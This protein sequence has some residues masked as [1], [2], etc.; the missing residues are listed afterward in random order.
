MYELLIIVLSFISNFNAEYSIIKKLF[1]FKG[2]DNK[3][4][5]LSQKSV[6]IKELLSYQRNTNNNKKLEI[7][8]DK[9]LGKN[10]LSNASYNMKKKL[11][12]F[13]KIKRKK[14]IRNNLIKDN[15]NDSSQK[16][17]KKLK[18]SNHNL[19]TEAKGDHINQLNNIND[20]EKIE[21]KSEQKNIKYSFNVGEIIVSS[22]FSCFIFGNLKLK[23]KLNNKGYRIFVL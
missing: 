13:K 17:Y 14:I 21:N 1:I 8:N 16:T 12:H 23:N 2:I 22:L 3:H 6:Q 18:I 4:F 20:N 19:N 9:D 15:D 5:H 11:N 7:N 10:I